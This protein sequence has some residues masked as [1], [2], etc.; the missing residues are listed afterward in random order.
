M[1]QYAGYDYKEFLEEGG[2][3]VVLTGIVTST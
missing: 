3:G 1:S 2:E